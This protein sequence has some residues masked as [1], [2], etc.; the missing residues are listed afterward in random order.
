MLHL[1]GTPTLALEKETHTSHQP[2]WIPE[3]HVRIVFPWM[4]VFCTAPAF[5]ESVDLNRE[6]DRQLDPLVHIYKT[7][8]AAPELSHHEART[9][10]LLAHE[11]QSLGYTVTD[12]L[13]KYA[14]SQWQGFGVVAVLKNGSGPTVLVRAD[15]DAL[16]VEEQTG[17]PYASRVRAADDRGTEVAVMHACGH[18]IH[19]T[20]LIGTARM[21]VAFRDRWA[22]TLVLV[23]QPSEERGD[24]ARALLA[25]GLY[26]KFPKPDLAVA[27]HDFG[28]LQAGTVGFTSGYMLAGATSVDVTIR[29]RGGHG[30]YPQAAKDPIVMAAEFILAIQ[31][32]VSREITPTDPAVVTVGSIQGG[33]K[34]N[35]IPD[36]VKLQL[37]I[38]AYA[39]EV[40]QH[41]LDSLARI[42]KGVALV[43]GVPDDRVPSV[44]VNETETA[45]PVYNDPALTERVVATLRDAVGPSNVIALERVM[46]SE[47][48]GAYG[49]EGHQIP[50]VF[51]RLGAIDAERIAKSKASGIP[52]P[53]LHSS[54][55]WPTPEL[56]VRTGVIAMTSVVLE[57]MKKQPSAGERLLSPR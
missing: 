48:F 40:R 33:T 10:S 1:P 42:A 28:D 21:L 17:L 53:S 11:L 30:A 39:P 56:T 6:V 16:P 38:R 20:V 3:H 47:D 18:D 19:T 46:G 8:H 43:G 7:I 55:F 14:N 29:G 24:G 57:L 45:A 27:L 22:G 51:F 52:L 32:I 44:S 9:S 41:I 35:I 12:H 26:T 4:L 2:N 34:Y 13:G 31:T 36:E 49:L 23:G 37:T 5:A 15:M 25:D 50:T 54:L